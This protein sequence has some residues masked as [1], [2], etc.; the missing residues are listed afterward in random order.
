[1]VFQIE[2]MIINGNEKYISEK[3]FQ[4]KQEIH[5]GRVG[6]KLLGSELK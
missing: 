4:T 2:K 1:M 5:P 3:I 6:K